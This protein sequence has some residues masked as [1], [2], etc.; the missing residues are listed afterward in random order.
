MLVRYASCSQQ[1]P[2]ADDILIVS[3][4]CAAALFH[5]MHE[6]LHLVSHIVRSRREE[7]AER[8]LFQGQKKNGV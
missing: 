5:R 3:V 1:W 7:F 4:L 8:A 2:Q 6:H